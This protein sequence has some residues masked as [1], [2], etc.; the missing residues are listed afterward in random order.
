MHTSCAH[1]LVGFC[2]TKRAKAI[3]DGVHLTATL[4][5]GFLMAGDHPKMCIP[6]ACI[7][8]YL[9]DSP[10][11]CHSHSHNKKFILAT[12]PFSFF[13]RLILFLSRNLCQCAKRL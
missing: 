5:H 7:P 8:V 2:I 6:H 1:E 13:L 10:A 3:L 12:P 4:L 11:Q 9:L